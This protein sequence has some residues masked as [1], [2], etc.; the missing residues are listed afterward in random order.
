MLVSELESSGGVK[1]AGP[2]EYHATV[3]I[4]PYKEDENV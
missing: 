1:I 2:L 3:E 4:Y